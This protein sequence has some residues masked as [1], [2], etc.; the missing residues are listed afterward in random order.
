MQSYT[1]ENKHERAVEKCGRS[2]S[3]AGPTPSL[4]SPN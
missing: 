4:P 1:I 2:F 3:P